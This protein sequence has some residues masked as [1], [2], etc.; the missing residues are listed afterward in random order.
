MSAGPSVH[1]VGGSGRWASFDPPLTDPLSPFFHSL[2]T[3]Y[4]YFVLDFHY[5]QCNLIYLVPLD[6][7]VKGFSTTTQY[8]SERCAGIIPLAYY[9]QTSTVY[10]FGMLCG[11][12]KRMSHISESARQICKG[13]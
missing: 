1:Q 3:N 12:S 9:M 11:L 10:L 6:Q 5:L 7:Y 4:L 2:L 8:V 13:M